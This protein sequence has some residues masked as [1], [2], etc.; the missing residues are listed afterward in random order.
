MDSSLVNVIVAALAF[1][2]AF[3]GVRGF[4]HLKARRQAN[5]A[6]RAG[7]ARNASAQATTP[8]SLNKSKRRRQEQMAAKR[9]KSRDAGDS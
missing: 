8:A 9:A 6:R 5:R 1:A 4:I 2:I 3:G 7:Q